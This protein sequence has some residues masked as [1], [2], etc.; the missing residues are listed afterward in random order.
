MSL[1]ILCKNC[2]SRS[3]SKMTPWLKGD[4]GKILSLI[5]EVPLY[6][7]GNNRARAWWYSLVLITLENRSTWSRLRWS[8]T[9]LILEGKAW[10]FFWRFTYVDDIWSFVPAEHAIIGL[11]DSILTRIQT[12]ESASKVFLIIITGNSIVL[13]TDAGWKCFRYWPPASG[14]LPTPCNKE[15]P[16]FD[17]WVRQRN[18]IMRSVKI[19]HTCV[20]YANLHQDGAGLACGVF[21][22]LLSLGSERPKV[23]AATHFHGTDGI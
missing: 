9:W 1:V 12:K 19:R 11:T 5:G 4:A 17:W 21:E 18:G 10:L 14:S 2:V 22:Y 13:I 23:I 16:A 20:F 7:L 6:D 3:S 15:K 8:F